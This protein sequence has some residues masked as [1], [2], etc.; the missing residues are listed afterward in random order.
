MARGGW[1]NTVHGNLEFLSDAD[2]RW[3][4]KAQSMYLGLQST[5]RTKTFGGIPGEVQPYGFGSVD[6]DGSVYAVV[7]PR[8]SVAEVALPKLSKSQGELHGGRIMFRDAGHLP[9]LQGNTLQLGP[10]QLALVGFGKY[11]RVAADLGVQKDVVIPR[12]IAPVDAV[13]SPV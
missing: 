11:A 2:A 13:F 1:I 5:G 10:G 3:F 4:A 7:N 9:V 6:A 8:Q 12:S